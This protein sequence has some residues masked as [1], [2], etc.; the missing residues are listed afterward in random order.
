MKRGS[1]RNIVLLLGLL[2]L[3]GAMQARSTKAVSAQS[4]SGPGFSYQGY[5]EDNGVPVNGT[6]RF[7]F[8]LFDRAQGGNQIGATQELR[9][10][11]VIEGSFAV[12]LNEGNQFGDNAFNGQARWL[13]ITVD[14]GRGETMLDPRQELLAVPY[15]HSLRPGARID[16]ALPSQ[17]MLDIQ[18]LAPSSPD[19]Y[20]LRIRSMNPQIALV[21]SYDFDDPGSDVTWKL[22]TPP[23]ATDFIES[24][25]FAIASQIFPWA[26]TNTHLLIDTNGN[27]GI[28]ANPVMSNRLTVSGGT[29]QQ[30]GILNESGKRWSMGTPISGDSFAIQEDGQYASRRLYIGPGG[31]EFWLRG[32]DPTLQIRDHVNDNSAE[33][34]RIE[35][36]ERAGGNFDG[37]AYLWWNGQSNKLMIGTRENG[38]DSDALVIDRATDNIGIGT[39]NPQHRLSLMSEHHQLA[40]TDADQ[41]DIMWTLSTVEH[42][43]GG[44]GVYEDGDSSQV[45]RLF[46]ANDSGN[47]GIGT[48]IPQNRLSIR[49]NSHQIAL[50]DANNNNKAWTLSTVDYNDGGIGLYEDGDSSQLPRLFVANNSGNVGIGTLNPTALLAVNGDIQAEEITVEAVWADFVFDEDYELMSLEEVE[51]YI[52]KYGHLPDVPSATEIASQGVRLGEMESTLLQKIEELTLHLITMDERLQ[53]L[54]Q[55]NARLN[56]VLAAQEAK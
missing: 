22:G 11:D 21:S 6:C 14:C 46:I 20:G 34:A 42:E 7:T 27:V 26:P 32:D 8:A 24:S 12:V 30:I 41:P 50:V 16:G 43:G 56:E 31:G 38:D 13:E 51:A 25:R 9:D 48:A 17:S 44:I 49:S 4:N 40:L 10:V 1:Y 5:L 53:E 55:E 29:N 28:G 52:H 37:G 36:L 15:A 35:L 2:V 45:P 54:E 39:T 47:V 23:D 33:A 3:V 19:T 18:Q